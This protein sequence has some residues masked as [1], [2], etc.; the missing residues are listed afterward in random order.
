[1]YHRR[2]N[3][4]K[5]W[6]A[7]MTTRPAKFLCCFLSC[8]FLLNGLVI[9]AQ[10]Q[11]RAMV[12]NAEQPN[13]WT[14][15]QAHYLLAQ[16][17]RRNLDLRAEG[18]G[19]LNPNEINGLN[20]EVLRTLVEFGAIY[21]DAARFNNSLLRPQ[22]QANAERAL[23]LQ[24]RRDELAEDSFRLRRDIARL[25]R[26]RALA[27][28]QDEKDNLAAQIA[29]LTALRDGNQTAIEQLDK[30][31]AAANGPSGD[32]QSTAPPEFTG[33]NRLP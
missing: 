4:L 21:D 31:I 13:V 29:E 17:H 24:R 26:Q 2:L 5:H 18:L 12:V 1:M 6:S 11:R 33:A 19:T 23:R 16:M 8:L 22:K 28:T 30:D 25:E 10:A 20:F 3:I 9:P 14:L 7:L 15:E 27:T 32:V